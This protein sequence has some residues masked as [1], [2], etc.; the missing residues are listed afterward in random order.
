MAKKL[1]KTDWLYAYSAE[2]HR[3]L[4]NCKVYPTWQHLPAGHMRYVDGASPKRA[5]TAYL[6]ETKYGRQAC[7]LKK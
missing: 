7:A 1:D 3:R 4:K 2:I 6:N 5:A